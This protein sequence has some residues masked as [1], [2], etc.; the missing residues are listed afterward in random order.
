MRCDEHVMNLRRRIGPSW[1][2][3]F[4]HKLRAVLALS[5][6]SVGVAAIVLTG[7]ISAG[8]QREILQR[9]ETMG[10]NLLVVRPAPVRR[11]V[12][13]TA[14]RGVFTTLDLDD[15]EAIL[16]RPLVAQAAPG[17]D[18]A[19][20][21]KRGTRPMITTV[22]GTSPAF[23][24]VRRF[25]LRAGR[26]FDEADD[27][28]GSRVAVLASRV[29]DTLFPS[30]S[31][32]GHEIRIRGVPFDVIG[33]LESK[34]VLADGSDEDNQVLVPITTAR[35]R[36]FN[37]TWL[38]T[39]FVSVDD[40]ANMDAAAADIR[41]LLRTRHRPIPGSELTRALP[42]SRDATLGARGLDSHGGGDAPSGEDAREALSDDFAIQNMRRVN[43]IQAEMADFLGR[44][45]MGL[46][47]IT[48][49]VGGTGI[50]G[51]M[52]MSV[53]ERTGEIGLRIAVGATPTDILAQFLFESTLLAGGGWLAGLA[54]GALGAT[55]VALGTEWRVALPIGP[56][57]ASCGMVIVIGL[58]FGA[59][60]ARKAS[61]LP[62][63]EA[64]LT[65]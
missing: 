26:F 17:V 25:R 30:E 31:A 65:E 49:I 14:I 45:T 64:L 18:G 54:V 47:A 46:A 11:L 22:R 57:L 5:S 12:A 56:L 60:P 55:A 34:G 13:R 6:V 44:L 10:T 15:Y 4:A 1:R 33:V 9:M 24:S 35:R 3:L 51:L 28:V 40:P 19:A 42:A 2:A 21:V 63:I 53:K 23:P 59:V 27:R 37:V 52:L 38:S 16:T 58:G 32:V 39:I 41:R 48:L 43:A 29:A 50:L 8:A 20:T 36:I 61:R 62:P 7:A